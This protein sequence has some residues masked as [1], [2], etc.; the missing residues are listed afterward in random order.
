[1][2]GSRW[3]G[4]SGALFSLAS[5]AFTTFS[6]QGL[7]FLSSILV[8]RAL[9]VRDYALFSIAT[10]MAGVLGGLADSGLSV[11]SLSLG[12][13]YDGNPREQGTL[14]A[15]CRQMLR[16][17]GALAFLAV[18]PLWLWSSWKH[19]ESVWQ[20]AW[21][22]G[23]IFLGFFA[24]LGINVYRSLLLVH[25]KLQ[26]MQACDIGCTLLRVVLMLVGLR[27]LPS[28]E[29]AVA[30]GFLAD[31]PRVLFYRAMVR[32]CVEPGQ[33]PS[34]GMR[35]EILG[36]LKR[37]MPNTIYGALSAQVQFVLLALLGN[38][39]SVAGAGALIRLHQLFMIVPS[40][41]AGVLNPRLA[42]EKDVHRL[43]VQFTRFGIVGT[44]LGLAVAGVIIAFPWLFLWLLGPSYSDYY[45]EARM[46]AVVSLAFSTAGVFTGLLASRGFVVPPAWTIGANVSALTVSVM[47]LPVD[48]L[49]GFLWMQV[50]VSSA[51][52]IVAIF[53]AVH[54]FRKLA[55]GHAE[56]VHPA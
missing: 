18:A 14:L 3:F 6:I 15:T 24:L 5:V 19:S 7:S 28:A 47:F 1:M 26:R 17:N 34:P 30:V 38:S 48:Q 54:F 22:G 37:T 4:K 53:G 16:F 2:T 39:K 11:A 41:S 40:F 12:G 56:P 45:F 31:V 52:L 50:L 10:S 21:I 36:I 49:R 25:H 13:R 46:M 42:R 33:P 55:A 20:L 43:P 32:G 27:F 9:T 23:F 29:T 8:I 35:R 44:G 51:A